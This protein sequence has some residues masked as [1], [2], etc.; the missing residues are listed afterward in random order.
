M[1]KTCSRGHVFE[2]TSACP[3]CPTCWPGRRKKL[4]GAGDLPEALSAPALRALDHAKI[5][6]LF[7]LSQR[8]EKEVAGLHGMGPKGV[9][10]LKE[11]MRKIGLGFAAADRK[12]R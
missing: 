8:T 12:A 2:K 1:R 4:L 5:H 9:R 7:R 11:A 3:T 10:I 6:S